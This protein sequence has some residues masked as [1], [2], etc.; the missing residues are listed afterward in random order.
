MASCKCS[1]FTILFDT[2]IIRYGLQL[3]CWTLW[4]QILKCSNWGILVLLTSRRWGFLQ[5]FAQLFHFCL[6]F[7][8][9]LLILML[10][11][12]RTDIQ[13]LKSSLHN[14]IQFDVLKK[15]FRGV[16]SIFTPY[17]STKYIK[18]LERNAEC[19][20]CFVCFLLSIKLSLF[21]QQA[22]C[23]LQMLPNLFRYQWLS[24]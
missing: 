15:F 1:G 20:T 2:K 13:V 23:L 22:S 7:L 21:H 9:G 11:Q 19:Y 5:V 14:T 18:E 24:L 4:N 8:W 10:L 17:D 16:A 3:Q 6:Q 12:L